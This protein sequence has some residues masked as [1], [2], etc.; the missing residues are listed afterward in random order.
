VDYSDRGDF[1]QTF[2]SKIFGL[3]PS[4]AKLWVKRS[5]KMTKIW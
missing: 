1:Q 2:A 5:W 3:R 4:R